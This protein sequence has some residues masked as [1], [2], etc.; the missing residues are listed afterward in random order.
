MWVDTESGF[1]MR[2]GQATSEYEPHVRVRSIT[3][4]AILIIAGAAVAVVWYF[5]G[6]HA[7]DGFD[8]SGAAI[9]TIHELTPAND[10]TL[11]MRYEWDL[12]GRNVTVALARIGGGSRLIY[13]KSRQG[14]W[15]EE[16]LMRGVVKGGLAEG[17]FELGECIESEIVPAP[18]HIELKRGEQFVIATCRKESGALVELLVY[19]E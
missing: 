8:Q 15:V 16:S 1:R 6:V 12:I 17:S 18:R 5:V 14:G 2:R 4:G 9:I 11:H 13:A 3:V 7:G 10:G 19:C